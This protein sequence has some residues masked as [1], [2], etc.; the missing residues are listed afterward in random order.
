MTLEE[1][2]GQ[3]TLYG[4]DIRPMGAWRANPDVHSPRATELLAEVRA[5]RVGALFN[6][7]GVASGLT[8]QRVAVEESRTH[9]PLLFAGDVIHGF[10][11]AF[12]IPLAEAASFEPELAEQTARVAAIEATAAGLDWNFAPMVDVA[13]DQRWGRVAEGSGEDVYL[14]KLFAAARVRGYQGSSLANEDSMLATPKHFAAYGAVSGGLDYNHVEISGQALREIHLPPFEAAFDAGALATMSAFNDVNGVPAS[15][16][17]ELLTAILRGEWGFRGFVV[18]DY[19]ADSELIAHGYAEGPRDATKLAFLAGVDMSMQSGFYA[20]YL[21]GL[22]KSGAVPAA[23]LDDAVRRV[24]EVKKALGLL[25]NP[26]RSLD[27]AR[28]AADLTRP[29]H[30]ALAREAARRSIVMLRN[31]RHVLPLARTKNVALIGPLAEAPEQ[32]D[33]PWTLFADPRESVTLAE[34]IRAALGAPAQLT[35]VQGSGF[36][37]PIDGGIRAAVEAAKAADVV[38]LAIGESEDMSGEAQSRTEIVVPAA[39][40]ALAEAVAKTGKPIVVLLRNGRALALQG[41]VRDASAILVTWFLGAETGNAVADVLF[42]N[43]NPSGRLPVSFPIESGQ[44]PFYYNH[45]STGRPYLHGGD[46]AFKA[47][48]REVPN[49]P[50]YPFGFGLSY[51]SFDYGAVKL[52]SATLPWD[53]SISVSARITNTSAQAGEEV[54]QLYIHDRVASVTRPVRELKGFRKVALAAGESKDVTFTLTR[55][56]LEFV[57]QDL[58]WLAEPGAFDVW[59]APS[60]AAGNPASFTLVE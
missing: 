39:Q 24:L 9:I 53:G 25:D 57:G 3:L 16:N 43:Y 20:R 59:V 47:R 55:K 6:G 8:I 34:G 30:R 42:G 31:E 4:D 58:Q 2:A 17:K 28:E 48:Y 14:G 32:L 23:R 36:D 44:E 5:G 18:S 41:A 60:A 12:P 56:N 46:A 22:V 19:T 10:K 29:E 15:A 11:T 49:E 38:L 26:Y 1:K 7:S 33:G 27:P 45:R 51:S 52:S 40:Q 50:L 13:R 37:A 54:V 21:P 35:V